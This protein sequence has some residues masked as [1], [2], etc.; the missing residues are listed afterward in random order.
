MK[1]LKLHGRGQGWGHH[2]LGSLILQAV[3]SW[4]ED[5]GQG[6]VG[7]G[8]VGTTLRIT[9]KWWKSHKR[10]SLVSSPDLIWLVYRFQYNARYWKWSVL[11][12]VLGLGLRLDSALPCTFHIDYSLCCGYMGGNKKTGFTLNGYCLPVPVKLS[13]RSQRECLEGA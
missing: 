13:I 4:A 8:G 9:G 11:G 12:L 10:L 5:G 2:T 3:K 6:E 1:P 7:E